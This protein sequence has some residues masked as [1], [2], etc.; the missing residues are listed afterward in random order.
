M[1]EDLRLVG[2][3]AWQA[4]QQ[5][6][7]RDGIETVWRTGRQGFYDVMQDLLHRTRFEPTLRSIKAVRV[8]IEQAQMAGCRNA[9]MCRIEPGSDTHVEVALSHVLLKKGQ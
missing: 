5:I 7:Q 1:G 2:H 3:G 6:E 8:E 9:G 4:M